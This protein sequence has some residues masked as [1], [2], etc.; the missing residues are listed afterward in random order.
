[1]ISSDSRY[2]DSNIVILPGP[3]DTSAQV[4]VPSDAESYT[5][6]YVYYTVTGMDRVDTIAYAFY[7]DAT[8]WWRF[9]DANPEVV[10][11]NDLSSLVSKQIRIPNS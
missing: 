6:N 11:W 3:D 8:Q 1:V 10:D 5:F 9:A 7:N 4:I 2:S